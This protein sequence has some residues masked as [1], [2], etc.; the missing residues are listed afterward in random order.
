MSRNSKFNLSG[1]NLY[2]ILCNKSYGLRLT[3]TE[4][5]VRIKT[6]RSVLFEVYDVVRC[7]QELLILFSAYPKHPRD[8]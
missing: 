4:E 6:N 5:V 3:A 8:Q 2:F 7:P 1:L